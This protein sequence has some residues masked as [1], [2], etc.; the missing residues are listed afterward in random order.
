VNGAD[1]IGS[2]LSGLLDTAQ[3]KILGL[4]ALRDEVSLITELAKE[5]EARVKT[6]QASVRRLLE[7]KNHDGICSNASSIHVV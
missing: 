3:D 5:E 2:R 1:L 4:D 6:I 7:V